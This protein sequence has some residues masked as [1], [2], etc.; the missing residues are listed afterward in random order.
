MIFSCDLRKK[1]IYS[2]EVLGY[3]PGVL[4]EHPSFA[5]SSQACRRTYGVAETGSP[6]SPPSPSLCPTMQSFVELILQGSTSKLE[7]SLSIATSN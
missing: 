4:W 6:F 2:A 1:Y 5:L 7:L 3:P